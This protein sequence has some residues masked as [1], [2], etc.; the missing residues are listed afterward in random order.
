MKLYWILLLSLLIAGCG[1]TNETTVVNASGKKPAPGFIL[2][3]VIT[4]K[5]SGTA[6]FKGK[7]VLLVFWR[8]GCPICVEE[9]P[10]IKAIQEKYKDKDF[11]LLSISV[12]KKTETLKKFISE[13][14]ITY[15]VLSDADLKTA[16]LYDVVGT[17]GFFV[18]DKDGFVL[19]ERQEDID[20]ARKKLESLLK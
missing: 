16:N 11:T 6:D 12:D 17:P 7:T 5:P 14:G 3:D 8:T 2:T 13:N 18:I 10:D 4:G 9:I 19:S 20:S 1:K 15:A